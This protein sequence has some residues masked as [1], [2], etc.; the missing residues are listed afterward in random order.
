MSGD[1]AGPAAPVK[2]DI[3]P[4]IR[5][6]AAADTS[7]RNGMPEPK[8][9]VYGAASA[10]R[11]REIARILAGIRAIVSPESDGGEG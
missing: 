9:Y 2:P 5:P 7:I 3:P 1:F 6:I 10:R 4:E 8:Y 11:E